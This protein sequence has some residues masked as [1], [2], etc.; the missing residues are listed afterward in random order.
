MRSDTLN[1]HG[2]GGY[3]EITA[4]SSNVNSMDKV[5]SKRIIVH[6]ILLQNC[7]ANKEE[8]KKIIVNE[9]LWQ[10]YSAD[11]DKLFSAEE[12]TLWYT[13]MEQKDAG[14][15]VTYDVPN[16]NVSNVSECIRSKPGVSY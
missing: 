5:E 1:W 2:H 13:I 11:V 10:N 4:P 16:F 12:Y 6:K 15:E 3:T 9:T 7:S 8:Y 14:N